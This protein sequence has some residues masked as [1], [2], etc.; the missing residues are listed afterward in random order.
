MALILSFGEGDR[1][2]VNDTPVKMAKIIT[3]EHFVLETG[4]EMFDVTGD[5][6]VEILPDVIVSAGDNPQWDGMA[7]V[8][9]NAPRDKR[10]LRE[11]IYW[12]EKGRKDDVQRRR[13][14]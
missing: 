3:D 11:P 1:F 7:Q 2:F 10:I 14:N 4:G 9:L 6:G 5:K 8:I 13:L 12:K